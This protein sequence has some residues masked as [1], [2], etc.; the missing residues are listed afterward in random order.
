MLWRINQQQRYE[1]CLSD[2]DGC[3]NLTLP[4]DQ[5]TF[6]SSFTHNRTYLSEKELRKLY[7][8]VLAGKIQGPQLAMMADCITVRA[9][10]TSSVRIIAGQSVK[11][12]NDLIQQIG[13]LPLTEPFRQILEKALD[14]SPGKRP[15]LE[16]LHEALIVELRQLD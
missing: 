14:E 1:G 9:F 5:R 12:H 6:T 2:L 11:T 7:N 3:L 15:E 16:E 8:A 13:T 10:A 4:E